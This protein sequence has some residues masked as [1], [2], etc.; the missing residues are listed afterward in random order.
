[1]IHRDRPKKKIGFEVKRTK[2]DVWQTQR[3]NSLS[4]VQFLRSRDHEKAVLRHSLEG[5]PPEEWQPLER[6]L[7]KV[8]ARAQEWASKIPIRCL[9]A[10]CRNPADLG[11]AHPD[12]Q[13]YLFR[14]KKHRCSE[15][16]VRAQAPIPITQALVPSWRAKNGTTF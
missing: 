7:E 10:G 15:Y 9:G 8:A 4:K 16:D 13:T 12:F 11:K 5:K 6:H 1:L 14:N 3:I 2:S